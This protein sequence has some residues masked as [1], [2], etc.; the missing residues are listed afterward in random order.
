M[1]QFVERLIEPVSDMDIFQGPNPTRPNGKAE[2]V[3]A[4][5]GL[6]TLLGIILCFFTIGLFQIVGAPFGDLTLVIIFPGHTIDAIISGVI[7][8]GGT[9]PLH[10]LINL[11]DKKS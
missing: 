7:V 9:K 4:L 11:F 2:K 3:V 6:A 8:G 10:D 1:A 5:W